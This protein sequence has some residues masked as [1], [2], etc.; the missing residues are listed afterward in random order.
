MIQEPIEKLVPYLAMDVGNFTSASVAQGDLGFAFTEYF[1]WTINSTS[2]LLDWTNPTMLRVHNSESIFPT[3]Y[4]VEPIE[5]TAADPTWAVYVIQDLTGLGLYHP[6][7]LHGHDFWVI[8]QDT[9]V[10]V[11]HPCGPL[12][13]P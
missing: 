12:M 7:H 8:G 1:T 6:I 9:G 10:F 11:S 5:I 2:L 13:P 4:N 3:E